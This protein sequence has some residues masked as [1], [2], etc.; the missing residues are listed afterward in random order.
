MKDN[1]AEKQFEWSFD[2][3]TAYIEYIINNKGMIFLTHTEVPAGLEGKGVG[4]K[5]VK[6]ALEEA[7]K[8]ELQVVPLCPFVAAYIRRHPKWKRLL[9]E[10]YNV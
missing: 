7:E 4:S 3:R 5:I 1:T 8:R 2:G 9:A 6:E 10:N